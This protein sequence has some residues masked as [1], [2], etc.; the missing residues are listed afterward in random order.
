MSMKSFRL[1]ALS[2]LITVGSVGTIAYTSC[3]KDEC[4]N[5][6]CF[7]GGTCSGGTCT[8]PTGYTGSSCQTK[9]IYGNWTGSDVCSPTGSYNVNIRLD[10]SST[11]STKVL[12]NNPGG[13]GTNNTISGTLSSDAR[14]V[15]YS[16]Q[17]VNA[18]SSPDT[19]TGS[20]TLTGANAFTHAYTA[21]EGATFSCSGNYT[22][23]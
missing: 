10:E 9:A 8:C 7:N 14:I 21:K 4:K 3:T 22:R 1:I 23:Q 5:V 18:S 6:N 16:N 17:I 13:F 19:L 15:T 11:D 12:I 2:A 20:I